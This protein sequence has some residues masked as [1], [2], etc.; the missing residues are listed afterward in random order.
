MKSEIFRSAYFVLTQE[1][2]TS[3]SQMLRVVRTSFP[4]LDLSDARFQY[5]YLLTR[6]DRHGRSGRFLMVDLRTAIGRSDPGFEA[7]MSELRPKLFQGFR[8]VGV[9]TATANGTLQVMRHTRQDGVDALISSNEA[10][11]LSFFRVAAS[12]K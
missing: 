3:G 11:L 4:F 10:D 5:S 7:L 1:N 12:R 6:I 2:L 8:R 9:L